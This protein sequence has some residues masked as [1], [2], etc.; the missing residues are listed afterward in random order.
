MSPVAIAGK[1]VEAALL[2]LDGVVTDT[3]RLHARCWK[4][5]FDDFLEQRTKERGEKFQPFD[6]EMDYRRYVDGKPRLDGVRDFLA[7]RGIQLADGSGART[8]EDSIAAIADR[9][10]ALFGDAL[11]EKGVDAYPGT[12][13]WV[14]HIRGEG[15]RVAIVSA[16]HHCAEVLRAARLEELFDVRVDGQLA[17]RLQLPGKPAPDVFLEAA[18]ALGVKPGGAVVVED[19]LAGVA[20]GRAGGFGLVIGVARHGNTAELAAAGADVVVADLEELLP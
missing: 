12:L 2:D 16:S 18:R 7:S 8:E 17:D 9:K 15:L 6:L 5:V 13:R 11:E 20:A 10:D 3:A 14:G 19:A 1:W 4:R